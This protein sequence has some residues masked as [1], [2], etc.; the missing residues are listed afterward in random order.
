MASSYK[1]S[2]STKLWLKTK[3]KTKLIVEGVVEA[4]ISLASS[5][6]LEN[7]SRTYRGRQCTW[8]RRRAVRER[9]PFV[10]VA[11]QSSSRAQEGEK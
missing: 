11:W 6:Y 8:G 9:T 1:P 4:F 5:Q 3:L 2:S 7:N 10:L